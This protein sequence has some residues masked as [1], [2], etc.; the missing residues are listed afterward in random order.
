M[1]L[2]FDFSRFGS[3]GKKGQW[4][5]VRRTFFFCMAFAGDETKCEKRVFVR[6][7]TAIGVWGW[8]VENDQCPV[9]HNLLAV[10]CT[11]ALF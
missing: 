8:D 7:W 2:F 5:K 3:K 1:F 11:L 4:T 9:C 10:P 6:K